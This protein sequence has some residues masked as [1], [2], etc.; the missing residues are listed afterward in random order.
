[1]RIAIAL[2]IA[3]AIAVAAF[4]VVRHDRS[5]SQTAGAVTLVGDSL[6]VGVEPYLD[7][8]LSGWRIDAHDLVGRATTEG[9]EELRALG[10]EL[11]PVVVVSLGTN[12]PDGSE[13]AFRR[14]RRRGDRP[15]RARP[16]PGV[17]DDRPGR[18]ATNRLQRRAPR[19]PLREPERPS[20]GLGGD[21]RRRELAARR[22]PGSR[23]ARGICP[24]RGGDRACGQ[25]V[26]TGGRLRVPAY[27][28]VRV[29]LTPVLRGVWR[30]RAE[31]VERIPAGPVIVVANHDSLSDPFFLGASIDRPLRFLTKSEL[32]SNR[33]VGRV[34]DALGGI[35]VERR[36]GDV[37]AVAAVARAL[38]AG[39]AVAIFPQGTV[40][41]S[42]DRPWQRGAAR[43]ALTTG[44]PIVPVAIVGA[45]DALRPGTR[46]PRLARVR[47]VVGEPIVVERA[48]P[49]IPATRELTARIRA[50]VETLV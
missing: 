42:A 49:T 27:E 18:I 12:D 28:L 21:R 44:A 40:L 25:V 29:V 35:P 33:I 11:A 31:G 32:W 23:H 9:I 2:V 46:L 15:R 38:E 30:L 3:V 48:S 19:G 24:A 50:A 7:E 16:V 37:A 26:P 14:A 17:G 22:G 43:V 34:L 20:R 36:R 8:E 5:E 39:D 6:N 4:A 45:S 47:V 10:A 1:M 13:A 41:G